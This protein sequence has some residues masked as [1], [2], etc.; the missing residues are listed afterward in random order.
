MAVTIRVD[1]TSLVFSE[2]RPPAT[3]LLA[4]TLGSVAFPDPDWD[5]F[6]LVVLEW[7]V[8]KTR[9]LVDG[10]AS[11]ANFDFMDDPVMLSAVLSNSGY[12][13]LSAVRRYIDSHEVVVTAT[14]SLSDWVAELLTAVG[15]FG[16][17]ATTDS[18]LRNSEE[19][20]ALTEAANAL[21]RSVQQSD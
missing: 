8:Q 4:V 20:I 16:S 9:S 2:G 3:G 11:S 12:M 14:V 15:K 13:K 19:Y 10:Q 1:A 18:V 7:W 21:A 17:R 5:D 6:V